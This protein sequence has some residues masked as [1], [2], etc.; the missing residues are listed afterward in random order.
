MVTSLTFVMKFQINERP[1]LRL[2]GA[3]E[4]TPRIIL[5]STH[6][7]C[8]ATHVLVPSWSKWHTQAHIT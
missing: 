6:F 5:T 7:M 1:C 4:L 2:D 8:R 3:L